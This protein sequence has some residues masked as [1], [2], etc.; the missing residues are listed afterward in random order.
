MNELDNYLNLITIPET[1]SNKDITTLKQIAS[2]LKYKFPNADPVKLNKYLAVKYKASK[3]IHHDENQFVTTLVR[4]NPDVLT[5]EF[6][7]IRNK[8]PFLDDPFQ[9]DLPKRKHI[10]KP[11]LDIDDR[12]SS[13]IVKCD[14]SR[15]RRS[16]LY[17]VYKLQ[18][19]EFRIPTKKE[20]FQF[21]TEK[22]GKPVKQSEYHYLGY[23]LLKLV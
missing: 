6:R 7:K 17:T 10:K 20:F 3:V 1:E 4:I 11:D 16:Q 9:E 15:I 14:T 23:K 19:Q 21:I 22:I 2:N 13:H 12:F 8:D 18:K 5:S